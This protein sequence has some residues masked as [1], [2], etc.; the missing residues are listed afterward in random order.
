MVMPIDRRRPSAS[1]DAVVH[2]P[3]AAGTAGE[4]APVV[5]DRRR[6]ASLRDFIFNEERRRQDIRPYR[7]AANASSTLL[8]PRSAK[9]YKFCSKK[10]APVRRA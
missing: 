7:Y 3:A 1:R 9:P 6:H 8:L 5:A 4:A 2:K 10:R